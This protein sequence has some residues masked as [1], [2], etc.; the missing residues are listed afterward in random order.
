M[1]ALISAKGKDVEELNECISEEEEEDDDDKVEE[2]DDWNADE[3]DESENGSKFKCL[4]CES[5]FSSSDYVFEHCAANHQFDFRCIKKSLGLDFYG[6]V[7]LI[8]YIREMVASNRCW[9]GGLDCESNAE[10]LKALWNDDKYLVPFLEDDSILYSFDDDEEEGDLDDT[11]MSADKEELLENLRNIEFVHFEGDI[12]QDFPLKEYAS[13]CNGS[14]DVAISSNKALANGK[15]GNCFSNKGEAKSNLRTSLAKVAVSEIR[16]VNESYFGSYSSFGIHREMLSDKARTDAYR[17]AIMRNPSLLD[18][19]VVLD[20]GCGTARAGASRVIAVDASEKMAATATQIAKENGL[21]SSVQVLHGMV[22]DLKEIQP[23]SVDVLVSEWMGYCLL[24]ESMLSSVL[25]AR[26]RWLKPGGAMLP[27]TATMFA[28]GFGK[29]GTSIQFWEDVYGF[30]MSCVGKELVEDAA[31]FPI[32]DVIEKSDI[33]TQTACLQSF[34]LMTMKLDDM[35]F[36][37]SIELAPKPSDPAGPTWCYGVVLWFE[38][39]FT[40]RFCKDTAVVLSTS[41]YEP[42]THWFQ[43]IL[44]FREPIALSLENANPKTSGAVG[45]NSC[46]VAKLQA[47]ISI[48][49]ATQHRAIDISMETVGV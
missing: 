21:L 8:N 14:S 41:P 49:R 44:T 19:A 43:T 35:D 40:S 32:V 47:R 17:Q 29:G 33:V 18:G 7:K 45:T 42:K 37:A 16:K 10:D 9:N 1:A 23:Q 38:T 46:P 2:W 24:Y 22:E 4:F 34:D 13:I 6:A 3:D 36:T 39:G 15:N 20:V 26:D 30:N 12:V 28:A 31:K 5:L 11:I 25:F 48:A 27:D